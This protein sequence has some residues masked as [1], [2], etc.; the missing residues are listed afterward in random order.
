MN[1]A[2]HFCG[3][4]A[5]RWLT[6][7]PIPVDRNTSRAGPQTWFAVLERPGIEPGAE[8]SI[9]SSVDTIEAPQRDPI[10]RKICVVNVIRAVITA[11][12]ITA[13]IQLWHIQRAKQV[14]G[15]KGVFAMLQDLALRMQEDEY[16]ESLAAKMIL[17]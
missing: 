6:D 2:P 8:R 13:L 12:A 14:A 11:R 10:P 16:R 4:S 1:E 9:G 3:A 5:F 15:L 17:R 7:E